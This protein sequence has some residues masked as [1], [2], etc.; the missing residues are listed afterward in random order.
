MRQLNLKDGVLAIT[1]ETRRAS[2]DDKL[3]CAHGER[4][5]GRF[6]RTLRF[7]TEID[8]DSVEASFKSG[9]LSVWLPRN[10]KPE[11]EAR[12]IAM[13][14]PSTA[15]LCLSSST[16]ASSASMRAAQSWPVRLE[17]GRSG[18]RRNC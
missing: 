16:T 10:P 6:R 7:A 11:A 3:S 9:V 15:S 8:A 17:P 1:G 5:H 13:P 2:R 12:R 14:G 4:F 18:R